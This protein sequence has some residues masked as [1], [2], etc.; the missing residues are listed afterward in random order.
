MR[1]TSLIDRRVVE[2]L[3]LDG[4]AVLVGPFFEDSGLGEIVVRGPAS[5]DGPADRKAGLLGKGGDR[6]QQANGESPQDGFCHWVED[7]RRC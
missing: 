4:D 5:V 7:Y 2:A 1:S 3:H 6:Q